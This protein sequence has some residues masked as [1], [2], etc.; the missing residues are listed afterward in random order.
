MASTIPLISTVSQFDKTIWQVETSIRQTGEWVEFQW[1]RLGNWVWGN[2]TTSVDIPIWWG[3]LLLWLSRGLAVLMVLWVVY[4]LYKQL[5]GWRRWFAKKVNPNEASL[6]HLNSDTTTIQGWLQQSAQAQAQGDY[7][8]ACRALYMA[9]LLRLEE[10]G[11]LY[12][13]R[14][15]TDREYLQ[16]LE[17]QWVLK[18]KPISLQSTW[19]RIFQV[20]ELTYYGSTS[21]AVETLQDCQHAY[22]TL[23]AELNQPEEV[24][25]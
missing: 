16:R 8:A 4:V 2:D 1:Q 25:S 5:Q 20:H 17:A 9:L 3:D 10:T 7:S 24:R 6:Q 13:D 15:Y 11:W 23:D 14:A 19:R 21:V 22:Q 18:A 12:R